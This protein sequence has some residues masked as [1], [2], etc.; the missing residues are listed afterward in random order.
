MGKISYNRNTTYTITHVYQKNG[1]DSDEGETLFF[2][3]K[4]D[5]YD[6]DSVDAS[7]IVSKTIDMDGATTVFTI[8]PGD[9]DDTVDPGKYFYDIKVK[10]SN[11]PPPIIYGVDSG[12]FT[13]AATPT[14]RES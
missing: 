12:T 13:L 4:A 14:N 7:A 9:I 10:E 2:T 1:V 8:D 11:G 3:V 6:T 5:E